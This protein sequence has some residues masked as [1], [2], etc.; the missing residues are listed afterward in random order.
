MDNQQMRIEIAKK[1]PGKKWQDKVR[2][3][4]EQQVYAV[5][6]SFKEKELKEAME[7]RNQE[8]VKQVLDITDMDWSDPKTKYTMT[9]SDVKCITFPYV[10]S[11]FCGKVICSKE[12][13][14][15]RWRESVGKIIE[16]QNQKRRLKSVSLIGDQIFIDLE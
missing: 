8:L 1:Y 16:I 3:M 9:M 2:K 12:D 7:K 11:V 5:Y 14:L 6:Q 4:S 13:L 15:K 10:D